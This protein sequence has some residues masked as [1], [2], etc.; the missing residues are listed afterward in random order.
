MQEQTIKKLIVTQRTIEKY[1]GFEFHHRILRVHFDKFA[2]NHQRL[3][4]QEEESFGQRQI[5]DPASV[6]L[7]R[8]TYAQPKALQQLY[9]FSSFMPQPQ[10]FTVPLVQQS[11]NSTAGYYDHS[12]GGGGG[13]QQHHSPYMAHNSYAYQPPLFTNQAIYA[14]NGYTPGGQWQQQS[15]Q[16]INHQPPF[17]QASF[18]PPQQPPPQRQNTTDYL[19]NSLNNLTLSNTT[20]T[21]TYN[22]QQGNES[23]G[24]MNNKWI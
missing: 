18:P 9:G 19:P 3:R 12:L 24:L 23:A 22:N 7:L 6:E 14:S 15:Y 13:Y 8:Q 20:T 16:S 5:C 2:L 1:N 4:E 11:M 17:P 10:P 21:S